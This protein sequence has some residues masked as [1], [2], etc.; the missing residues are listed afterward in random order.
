MA[1]AVAG[2]GE[3][4]AGVGV[5]EIVIVI[6]SYGEMMVFIATRHTL[7]QHKV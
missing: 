3:S 1:T 4:T 5:K 6:D 2:F 7:Y